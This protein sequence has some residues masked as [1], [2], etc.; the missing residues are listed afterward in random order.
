MTKIV[1]RNDPGAIQVPDRLFPIVEDLLLLDENELRGIRAN[2]EALAE[3]KKE[4]GAGRT[5]SLG[6]TVSGKTFG[7]LIITINNLALKG[8]GMLFS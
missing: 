2:V 5:S 7:I 3:A 1:V 6:D 8:R 4:K